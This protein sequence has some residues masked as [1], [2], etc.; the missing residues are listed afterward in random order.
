[1]TCFRWP[2]LII[3]EPEAI[4][5]RWVD[6]GQ[7][8]PIFGKLSSASSMRFVHSIWRTRVGGSG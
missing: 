6:G 5:L 7:A 4:S 8:T 1:M 3:F 2:V